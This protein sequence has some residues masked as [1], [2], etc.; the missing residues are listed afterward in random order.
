MA[1]LARR[2]GVSVKEIAR[3]NRLSS[4]GELRKGQTVRIP[5]TVRVTHD[6]HGRKVT[7]RAVRGRGGRIH[8][9]RASSSRHG[10]GR[11]SASRGHSSSHSSRGRHRR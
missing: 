10:G 7:V 6:R 5:Q 11:H 3:M 2:Y 9:V 1:S 4:R 8:E